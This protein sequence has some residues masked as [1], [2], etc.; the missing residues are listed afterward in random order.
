MPRSI[1]RGISMSE[2][3]TRGRL[4]SRRDFIKNALMTGAVIKAG[5]LMPSNHVH[6]AFCRQAEFDLAV[7][8]GDIKNAVNRAIEAIGGMKKFMKP[9]DT[10][11]L[12]PNM[13]FPNPPE[14]GTTTN[15]EMV[16]AV[17][18]LS[19]EAGARRILVIDHTMREGDICFKK[20]GL[21]TTLETLEK[22]KIIPIQTENHFEEIE[23]NGKALKSI[24]IAKLIRRGVLINLPC[25]K[26]HNATEVSFSLKNLMGLVWDRSYFHTSTDLH[27][28]I[29]ELATAIR[30]QLTVLDG[31]RALLTGGPTGPGKVRELHTVVAGSDPLAVD[32]F[33]LTLAPFNNRSVATHSITHLKHAYELGVGEIDLEKLKI[34]TESVYG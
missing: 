33:G 25:L 17:A 19:I 10:V 15:P 11:I 22:V 27:M 5:T 13:S 28:A 29:A 3:M 12:K 2:R 1:E 31:T 24:K 34:L 23:V 8:K 14:W 6:K 21:S 18:E 4:I 26:S 7:I 16:R 9:G 20:T 30:P 32:A